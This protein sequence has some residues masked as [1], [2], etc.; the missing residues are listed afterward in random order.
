MLT[1]QSQYSFQNT[2]KSHNSR[3]SP[4]HQKSRS[5]SQK[6]KFHY[7]RFLIKDSQI[8][9]G[10][11]I[12]AHMPNDTSKPPDV[13]DSTSQRRECNRGVD[14]ECWQRNK[15]VHKRFMDVL[16]ELGIIQSVVSRLWQRFQDDENVS[17]R[18]NT[19]CTRVI[20]PYEDRYLAVT[21]KRSRR[22]RAS[23]LSRKICS[24]R[25]AI[26]TEFVFIDDNARLHQTNIVNEYFQSEFI[27]PLEWSA[28]PPSLNPAQHVWLMLGQRVKSVFINDL[29]VNGGTS[30]SSDYL[31]ETQLTEAGGHGIHFVDCPSSLHI[32]RHVSNGD[33]RIQPGTGVEL[34][35][36]MSPN[37]NRAPINDKY[38]F[39]GVH[40]IEGYPP[41]CQ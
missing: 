16:E 35:S 7:R 40:E 5:I 6:E 18:Y 17:R 8:W 25:G 23:Y 31:Q 4:L 38:V 24:H 39:G 37:L 11:L 26:S 29:S 34:C 28:F 13:T 20:T 12:S 1:Q 3:T 21:P 2:K 41:D 9:D 30:G 32:A 10:G 36:M 22:S 15:I 14:K 33:G 27:T 19:D